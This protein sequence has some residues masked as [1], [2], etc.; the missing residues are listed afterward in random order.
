VALPVGDETTEPPSTA[1]V[2]A[3]GDGPASLGPDWMRAI[4]LV[5]YES[6]G[7]K[8]PAF[9]KALRRAKADGATH[10]IFG[11]RLTAPTT[12]SAELMLIDDS[13]TDN[14]L[15]DALATAQREGLKTVVAPIIDFD[16]SYAGDYEPSDPEAFFDAYEERV[17]RYADDAGKAGSDAFV[18]G[19]LLSQLDG[20]DYTDRW[21]AIVADA[22]DRCHCRVTYEAE[23]VDGAERVQFWDATDAIWVA[24]LEQLTDEPT[25]DVE[26]L[27]RAWADPKRRLHAL[28]V[29]WEKPVAIGAL[30]YESKSGASA[31]PVTQAEGDVSQGAQAALFEAAFRAFGGTPW[32]GGI[33]WFE[34]NVDGFE[35]K[36]DD[37]GFLGKQAEQVV[38]DWQ[39]AH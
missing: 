33:A 2:G 32:F 11:P 15:A 28:N 20:E 37:T 26:T 6:D 10:V 8:N 38:R 39:T 7:Y 34:F 29:R 9:V 17:A 35:P 27:V 13:P 1:T 4:H 25:D 19:S 16:D 30:G 12:T 22:R 24:P 14:T 18:V 31:A 3:D 21:K 5:S 36:P 23:N